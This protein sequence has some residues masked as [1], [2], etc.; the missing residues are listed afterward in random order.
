MSDFDLDALL[1]GAVDDYQRNTMPRIKP[2]GTAAA[3]A[4]ATHRRRVHTAAMS[5]VALVVI[6][7]PI[8]AYAA[9]D[10]DHNGPPN[11]ASSQSASPA[12]SDSPSTTPT[13]P[14]PTLA[15]ITEQELANATLNLPT[16]A[17]GACPSGTVTFH[18]GQFGDT[19][20]VARSLLTKA[21][22]V[23][24]D[25]DGSADAVAVFECQIGNPS[26]FEAVGFHRAADN[27]I[28]TLG[29][30]VTGINTIADIRAGDGGTVQLQVSNL[31]GSDGIA[32]TGQ[33]IQWRTYD[34]VGTR[35]NQTA[36]STSF[37]V[38][39]PGLTASVSDATFA[40]AVNGKRTGTMTVTLHNGGA[41]TVS[42][43]T[44][45]YQLTIGTVRTPICDKLSGLPMAGAC[46]VAPIAPGATATVTFTMTGDPSVDSFPTGTSFN[47][48]GENLVQINIGDQELAVQPKLGKVIGPLPAGWCGERER[49]VADHPAG[50]PAGLGG[51]CLVQ[52]CWPQPG[53]PGVGQQGA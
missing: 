45:V 6:A 7:A 31:A 39:I 51:R 25:H 17:G 21:A 43:A 36:G 5:A 37:T 24:L 46:H 52:Q 19:G 16:W 13:T 27:S 53:T 1:A 49:R 14:A 30:V 23:D 44:I 18:N 20:T 29:P 48:L 42:N 8:A 2:A 22:S 38:D 47:V 3:R 34:W 10:H 33:I 28:Q 35:F 40:A 4:T 12:P 11:V 41:T 26:S 32:A 50:V 15:P 9:T